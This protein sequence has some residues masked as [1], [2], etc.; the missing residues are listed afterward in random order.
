MTATKA[1]FNP[2]ENAKTAPKKSAA[3]AGANKPEFTVPGLAPYV[4]LDLVEKR[5]K[6]LKAVLREPVNTFMH[7]HFV[8]S[9]AK[10]HTV[11][12]N[13]D[14]VDESAKA[15]CQLRK[16]G[17]NI[18]LSP[19]AADLLASHNVPVETVADMPDT[20]II[21]PEY[22]KDAGL[23]ERV[24]KALQTVKDLPKDFIQ[25]QEATTKRVVGEGTVEAV[26]KLE[27]KA[28]IE[29][30]LP[31]VTT[32]AVRPAKSGEEDVDF[33]AALEVL[34]TAVATKADHPVA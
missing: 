13:F 29:A 21:N 20:F 1:K 25:H 27:D 5:L 4:A 8:E 9:A 19:E 6:S 32:L 11:P 12:V 3:K 31:L 7:T 28:T 18:P 23:M 34:M 16:N 33:V 10:T 30:L 22:L 15:N 26:C 2:F 17:A 24:A 14:G